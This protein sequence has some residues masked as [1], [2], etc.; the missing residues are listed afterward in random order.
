MSIF[1]HA[2][3]SNIFRLLH[4]IT[5][6]ELLPHQEFRDA[7]RKNDFAVIAT[8]F[9]AKARD[10]IINDSFGEETK[11][12]VEESLYWCLKFLSQRFKTYD[13]DS[14]ADGP[15]R[16]GLL[17]NLFSLESVIPHL[18]KS[19][20]YCYQEILYEL[21]ILSRNKRI[22]KRISSS[23]LRLWKS[24]DINPEFDD[25]NIWTTGIES[26]SFDRQLFEI[27]FFRHAL[28]KRLRQTRQNPFR[29]TCTNVGMHCILY[30]CSACANI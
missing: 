28:V 19:A 30:L 29:L 15:L 5:A 18:S 10:D 12:I 4:N 27:E 6:G 1:H 23:L 9:I 21:V 26:L 16:N 17:P 20:F 24:E 11:E 25:D 14:W 7:L 3:A 13:G 22:F 2:T 8:A